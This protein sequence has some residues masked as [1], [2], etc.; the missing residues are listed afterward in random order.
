ML[1]VPSLP[2]LRILGLSL[3]N[4]ALRLGLSASAGL[5]LACCCRVT[6][7]STFLPD[8]SA[9]RT[10]AAGAAELADEAED[11]LKSCAALATVRF[12]GG[13]RNV[14]A[15]SSFLPA[16]NGKKP[17][18]ECSSSSSSSLPREMPTPATRV[19]AGGRRKAW[20]RAILWL[21][22]S[23]EEDESEVSAAGGES[24]SDAS[25]GGGATLF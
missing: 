12:C 19:K 21:E 9:V 2:S 10:A 20:L 4:S 3:A 16:A 18:E 14:A 22:P 24:S 17:P 8:S 1:G 6:F 25:G 13:D 23:S 7:P 5:L 11:S 15:G